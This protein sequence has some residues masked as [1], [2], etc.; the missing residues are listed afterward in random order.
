MKVACKSLPRWTFAV[1]CNIYAPRL[2]ALCCH[3]PAPIKLFTLHE[4]AAPV[5]KL[6]FNVR[7]RASQFCSMSSRHSTRAPLLVA[8][9]TSHSAA[10]AL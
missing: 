7:T 3:C 5:G 9:T 8:G 6:L 10:R 1:V 2:E 4:L